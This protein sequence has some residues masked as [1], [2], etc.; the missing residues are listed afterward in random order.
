[1]AVD[2]EKKTV[3]GVIGAGA[4]GAGIVQIGLTAGLK[5]ILFDTNKPALAP[6]RD[7]ILSRVQ[8][9]I[10]KGQLPAEAGPQA[11]RRAHV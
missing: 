9:Q 3:M 6:A 1:M 2:A 7:Q 5:V 8:R 11:D 10:E 4:M